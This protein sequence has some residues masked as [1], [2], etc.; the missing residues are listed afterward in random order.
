M[1]TKPITMRKLKDILRLKFSAKLS[2]RQIAR[3][4]S[5]S[6]SVISTYVNRAAQLGITGWPL[7]ESWTDTKLTAQFLTT[8]VKPK[9][10][11]LPDWSV[12]KQ[13]LAHPHVTLQLLWEEYVQQHP[14]RHYSYNHYC[15]CYKAWLMTQK[16]SMRQTHLAGDK[17][18]IDYCGPKVD[19]IDRA[20]G[21]CKSACIFV[22]VLGASNYTFVEATWTQNLEDWCMSHARCFEFLEG[23]PR[24]LVP[25]NL[26]SAVHKAHRYEPDTN[27]TY[28][29]LAVYYNTAIMP[30]RP[31]KPKDKAKAE[32]A[33]LIV[34]RWIIA[35][36][37]H[38]V[39]YSL[40]QLN[41]RILE[42]LYQ[43]NSKHMR[44]YNASRNELFSQ[45]DRPALQALPYKPY[46]Y[47]RIK[48]V[49][50]HMDYHVDVD[51]HFYSVPY[52]LVKQTLEAHICNELV[53][54]Y[55]LGN[56]VAIHPR[57]RNKGRHTTAFEHMPKA[58]QSM[59]WSP[60]RIQTWAKK[61]GIHAYHFVRQVMAKRNHAEQGYRTCIGTLNLTKQYEAERVD[62]ACERALV[63][64]QLQM[65]AVKRIL[66]NNADKLPLRGQNSNQTSPD[67]THNNIR[68][69]T[70]Y[71]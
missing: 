55:H 53:T 37:R 41:E 69:N 52:T 14:G 10:Y 12:V 46:Q 50:V 62:A 32:N 30:T 54:I 4:L 21:E 34:E 42:C 39:F 56:V 33:V 65:R 67:I 24:L 6:P 71:Q 68:G 48:K 59:Q 70:Y 15:R 43:L 11:T 29:Q 9:K 36:L 38:E 47:T 3:S 23:V 13:E 35:K 7:D 1:P 26:K 66:E 2:H 16:P 28:Q 49:R 61:I 17:L 45:I 60:Q 20:T 31:Y 64:G 27:P 58:H 22:A 18:F 63:L 40:R 5:I 8:K 51:K 25:D 57:N 19:I 44:A